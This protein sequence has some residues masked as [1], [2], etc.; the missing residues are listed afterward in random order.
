[1]AVFEQSK[2]LIL[3]LSD[4]FGWRFARR[5]NTS[6]SIWA[7]KPRVAIPKQPAKSHSRSWTLAKNA[8]C[9][10]QRARGK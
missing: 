2:P 9:R 1:M 4:Y 3:S 10:H 6:A 5:I 8:Q 7:A